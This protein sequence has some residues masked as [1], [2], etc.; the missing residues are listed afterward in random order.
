MPRSTEKSETAF[1]RASRVLVGGVNSPARTF[2]AVGGTPPTIARGKGSRLEDLDG[3]DYVDYVGSYGP[4]ILG[5]ADEQVVAAVSKAIHKGMSFGAPTEAETALAEMIVSGIP[6]VERVRFVSSG[7]EAAMSAVRLARGATGRSRIVKTIGCYHG[8]CDALLVS[9]GSGASTLGVP[10]SPGVP[11]GATGDT[12]LVP[13]NDLSAVEAALE[14]TDADVAAVLVEPIAGNMGVIPPAEGYLQGLRDLCDRTGALLV[15]DEVMTGFRVGWG[16]AQLLYGVTP[17]LTV[18]GKVIGGGMPVGAVAGGAE[19][20]DHL[21]PVGPVYQAGTLSGNPAAM[22]AGLATLRMCME[23]G[24]YARLEET[25]A[26]VEEALAAA[27]RDAGLA[28]RVC[29]QRVGSMLC[30]FFTPGPVTS[31]DDVAA[32]DHDAFAVWFHAMLEGGIYLPPSQYEANFVSAAHTDRDVER[33]AAAAADAF[34][35]AADAHAS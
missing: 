23:E 19:L 8:H 14:K 34:A 9:A 11:S 17:D 10:S 18:L 21:A 27:A 3:N 24:F 28:E 25:A 31:Y 4:M 30:C 35:R 2:A 13:Y 15:F 6:S 33:T 16:G 26:A 1:Q 29:L 20:M 7:T 22:A 12:L 32:C 5:H